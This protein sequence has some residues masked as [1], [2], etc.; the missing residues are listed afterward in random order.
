M[1]LLSNTEIKNKLV[2]LEQIGELKKYNDSGISEVKKLLDNH[3]HN[4]SE[5]LSSYY[6]RTEVDN[7]ISLIPKFSIKVVSS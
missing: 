6:K 4:V 7:L 2:T 3:I 5:S 1:I